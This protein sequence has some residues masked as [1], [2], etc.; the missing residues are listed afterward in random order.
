MIVELTPENIGQVKNQRL[1]AYAAI[2]QNIEREFWANVRELGLQVD[3]YDDCAEVASKIANVVSKG[4]ARRNDDKSIVVNHISPSC[5]ACQTGLGTATFFISLKCHRNCFFCFNPNQENYAEFQT[6][7]RD[8]V[9]ELEEI[10]QSGARLEHIALTGGEPLLHRDE[11]IEFFKYAHEKFPHAYK[12]L[13]TSGDHLDV[14]LLTA[15][16][17]AHLDEIRFSIR[18]YDSEQARRHTY[19][20]IA[21]AKVYIPNVM[22]EM[23]VLPGAL[24]EMKQVLLK[25]DELGVFGI[26]LLEFCFPLNNAEVY[27]DKGYRIKH[28]PFRVL[29]NYSYAG[30][31]P[32]AQSEL[33]CLDLVE[34]ALDQKL[35]LG[36]HYC[37]LENKHTGEV[38]Q[39]HFEQ[40]IPAHLYFSPKD[41]FLKSAKVFGKDIHQVLTIFEK[42]GYRDFQRNRDRY[43][44]EFHVSQIPTLKELD[45][46]IGISTSVMEARPDG[47][48]LRELKIDVT[49]PQTFDLANDV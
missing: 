47:N 18:L 6:Q 39:H 15:L 29:Y 45:L 36:V 44:L 10:F 24:D 27:R 3:A 23:P 12:R 46:E 42:Q 34:F 37:S 1:A 25:L 41:Y 43:Y 30:G 33:D 31:L 4:A 20:R 32:V 8:C 9:R 19:D 21:L 35:K 49:T 22:V 17:N 14:E 5:A 16:Q 7:K 48:V 40:K 13:Y 26:N 2:Y 11:T 38:Y 28:R